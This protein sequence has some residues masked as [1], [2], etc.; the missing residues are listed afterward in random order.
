[1]TYLQPLGRGASLKLDDEKSELIVKHLL[2]V[3]S[4][5]LNLSQARLFLHT[6]KGSASTIAPSKN[7]FKSAWT[8]YKPSLF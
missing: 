5:C 8:I 2:L 4:H 6:N 1:M 7:S 3:I